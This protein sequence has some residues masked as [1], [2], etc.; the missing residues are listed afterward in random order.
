MRILKYLAILII[1][2]S[3]FTACGKKEKVMTIQDYAKIESEV[4]IPDPDLDPAKVE[5][6]AKKYGFTFEQYREFFEKVQNDPS[7]QEKLGEL[8]LEDQKPD[9][10]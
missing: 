1:G 8:I 5:Q 10:K 3:L 9:K 2:L 6:V 7:L 4:A